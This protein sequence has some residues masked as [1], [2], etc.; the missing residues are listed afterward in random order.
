MLFG[1]GKTTR[2]ECFMMVAIAEKSKACARLF[3]EEDWFVTL[4]ASRLPF[5]NIAC[6]N[7]IRGVRGHNQVERTLKCS[8]KSRTSVGWMLQNTDHPKVGAIETD[9]MRDGWN[10]KGS[11]P[12]APPRHS[13]PISTLPPTT[14]TTTTTYRLLFLE[15]LVLPKSCFPP[16]TSAMPGVRSTNTVFFIGSFDISLTSCC[17]YDNTRRIYCVVWTSASGALCS[18]LSELL[19]D[20][21]QAVADPCYSFNIKNTDTF[22]SRKLHKHVFPAGFLCVCE[23]Q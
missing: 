23:W 11:L 20:E 16:C 18:S 9:E 10:R 5:K 21:C 7:L 22:E 19:I 12:T 17:V 8:S 4:P 2:I 13:C 3:S 15:S 14:S 6:S 1:S